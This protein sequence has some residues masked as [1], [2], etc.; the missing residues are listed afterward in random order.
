M[1]VSASG[2]GQKHLTV[3]QCLGG[4]FPKTEPEIFALMTPDI[5][6]QTLSTRLDISPMAALV[7]LFE[8][9]KRRA[10]IGFS[11]IGES[12]QDTAG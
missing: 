12:F 4:D 11:G 3:E 2:T 10:P 7:G 5:V 8:L 9:L 1:K 6:W